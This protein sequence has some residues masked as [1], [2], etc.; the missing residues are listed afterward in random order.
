MRQRRLASRCERCE[1][2]PEGVNTCVAV[3]SY[4]YPWREIV[5]GLK[6][7]ADLALAPWMAALAFG[8]AEVQQALAGAD[9]VLPMPLSLPR[10]AERGFNQAHEWARHMA[11][12]KLVQD[13]VLRLPTGAPQAGLDMAERLAQLNALRQ[14]FV[15]HPECFAQIQG[16]TVLLVD[17]VQTTGTTLHALA[18]TLLYAGAR[19]VNALVFARAEVA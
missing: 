11:P 1:W 6:Y 16:K 2:R 15:V 19:E 12:E 13:W 9:A 8:R 7:Q 18:Q 14:A 4:E 10:L 17:D 5:A 3:V